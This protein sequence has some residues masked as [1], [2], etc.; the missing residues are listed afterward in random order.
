LNEFRKTRHI[1]QHICGV[2]VKACF[3]PVSIMQ[4][5]R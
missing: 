4:T 2:C 5:E 3:G 1:Q